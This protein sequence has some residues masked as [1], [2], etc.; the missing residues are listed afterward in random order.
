MIEYDV[1]VIPGRGYKDGSLPPSSRSCI[2]KAVQ[3]IQEGKAATIVL[4]GKYS[5][6]VSHI[7]PKTEAWVMGE[8]AV[9]LN[10]DP[11]C[12]YLEEESQT[13]VEN[14]YFVKKQFLIPNGWKRVCAI[15]IYPHTLRMQLNAEYVLGPEYTIT[16]LRTDFRFPENIQK[17]IEGEETNKLRHAKVFLSQFEKGDHEAIYQAALHART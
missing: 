10:I 13:T 9:T 14:F 2:E 17:K 4:S 6:A 16:T 12:I 7:P 1:I 11:S 3:L 15:G 5:H 8:Y